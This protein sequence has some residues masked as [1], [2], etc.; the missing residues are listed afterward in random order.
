MFGLRRKRATVRFADGV[1][2]VPRPKKDAIAFRLDALDW[3]GFVEAGDDF[4]ADRQGWWLFVPTG[5]NDALALAD[6]CAP[7]DPLAREGELALLLDE[8]PVRHLMLGAWP[9][10]LRLSYLGDGV[11]M[12]DRRARARIEADA[13]IADLP[14][15]A[16]APA[17]I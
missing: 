6:E 8:R 15:T 5:E 14:R 7:I 9:R 10:R 17:I 16:A 4:T 3:T 1:L 13:V 2:H 12:L 11:T